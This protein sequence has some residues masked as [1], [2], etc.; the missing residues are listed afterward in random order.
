MVMIF[1]YN[2]ALT[3]KGMNK[4]TLQNNVDRNRF[5]NSIFVCYDNT[6]RLK[7]YT[8]IVLQH[9]FLSENPEVNTP[10][11]ERDL[12]SACE[13]IVI[14][15]DAFINLAFDLGPVEGM[16]ANDVKSYIRYIANR[17]LSQ[18]GLEP[19]YRVKEHPLP[20]LDAMLSA[21]EHVN[22]FENKA[23]E[24]SKAATQ[25]TWEDAFDNL[26]DNT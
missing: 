14:H 20:W 18:L 12:Y 4:I 8:K 15:E 22:F 5:R 7:K 11:L 2:H 16:A 6:D 21:V 24:Y 17:R 1:Y 26:S 19:I 23:T 3:F 13:T 25:G 9:T 10:E